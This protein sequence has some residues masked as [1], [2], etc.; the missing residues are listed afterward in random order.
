[1][2]PLPDLSAFLRDGA[3]VAYCDEQYV[4]SRREAG[5]LVLPSGR[6][7]AC[8]PL[9][10]RPGLIPLPVTVEPGRYR[11]VNVVLCGPVLWDI[12]WSAALQ[13]VIRDEPVWS[14]EDA[15]AF[16]AVDRGVA[17]FMDLAAAQALLAWD[18]E[19]V[20]ECIVDRLDEP[21]VVQELDAATGA[22]VIICD[23]GG[24][25]AYGVWIGRTIDGT[26]ACLLTDFVLLD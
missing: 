9:T 4:V 8:D 2:T 18:R 19:T 26:V 16:Y 10:M 14:W 23:S 20:G 17:C 3:T 5:T 7:V 21:V 15:D 11:V 12:A 1:M 24:D 25:G 22:N 13:L 6:I